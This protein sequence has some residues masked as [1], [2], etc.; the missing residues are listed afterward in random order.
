MITHSTAPPNGVWKERATDGRL[1]LTID[2]S[3]VVMK[4]PTTTSPST[5]HL[6][7]GACL[8]PGSVWRR[9]A[10]SCPSQ[11]ADPGGAALAP[12]IALF[13]ASHRRA[14]WSALHPST[15]WLLFNR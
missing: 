12:A 9:P 13:S 11:R 4:V 6:W 14:A 1:M 5:A 7:V 10:R 15:A 2:E 8:P 3:R